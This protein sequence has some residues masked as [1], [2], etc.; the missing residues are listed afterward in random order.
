MKLMA[1]VGLPASGKTTES[2]RLVDNGW[3]RVNKDDLRAMLHNSKWS[4]KNEAQVIAIRD[5]VII[6][7][8]KRGKSVVVDDTNFNESHIER[9]KQLAKEFNATFEKKFIDTPIEEC[10]S[11]DLARQNSVGE[12]VIRKM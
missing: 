5:A 3:V 10:I 12:K 1:M 11:R 8:L 9:F 7:A 6:D 2:R 4:G